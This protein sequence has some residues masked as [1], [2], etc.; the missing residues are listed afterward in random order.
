MEGIARPLGRPLWSEMKE[1]AARISTNPASGVRLLFD[2][3]KAKGKE[4]GLPKIRLHLIGH[5]AA[6]NELTTF[7]GKYP[8]RTLKLV[9]LDA[10]YDRRELPTIEAAD[11]LPSTEQ[12]PGDPLRQ[13]IEAAHIAAMAA[14]IPN[15][16]NIKAPV[17]N[18]YAMFEKH[19]A[20]KPDT[21]PDKQK[22]AEAFMETLVRPYQR[23][24][25]DK[26][27]REQPAGRVIELTG[28]HHYFFRDPALREDVVKTIR[29]FLAGS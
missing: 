15:Y 16:K 28:T 11:P 14:Y 18:Y 26:F 20:V 1:N 7:A 22:V 12:P 17:L 21:P 23:K 24:N 8:K 9:Y 13:K 27:R 10:A 2:L 4:Y 5:S 6:G 25:I 29:D 19:W 3:Y